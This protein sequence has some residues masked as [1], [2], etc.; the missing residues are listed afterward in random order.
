MAVFD[1]EGLL[2]VDSGLASDTFNK[3]ARTR[4]QESVYGFLTI[5]QFD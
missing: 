2:V 1:E 3:I 5:G 4:L